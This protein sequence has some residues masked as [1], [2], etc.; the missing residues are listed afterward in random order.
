M[1]F[2]AVVRRYAFGVAATTSYETL[3]G[4]MTSGDSPGTPRGF[5]RAASMT[6]APLVKRGSVERIHH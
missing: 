3:C 2:A 6:D 4:M 5:R 1:R